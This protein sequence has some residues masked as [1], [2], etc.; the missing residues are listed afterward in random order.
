M[1]DSIKIIQDISLLYE[2]SLSVGSSLDPEE[3]CHNF[4]YTLISRKSLSFG[5]IWLN[6]TEPG[7]EKYCDLFYIYPHFQKA[8]TTVTCSHYILDALAKKP[9]ISI[10]NRDPEFESLVHEKKVG[11]GSYCI[12]S[13]G[14]L[15]FLK[16]FAANR[17]EGFDKLEMAQLKQVVDKLAISLNGCFAHIHLKEETDKKM[18]AQKALAE[19]ENKLRRMIDSSLDAVGSVDTDGKLVEWN[20]QAEKMFGHTREEALGKLLV[21]LI[22]PER[23]REEVTNSVREYL[24]GDKTALV[25][26]RYETTC[27]R[28]D[29]SEFLA[30][31]SITGD[32]NYTNILFVGFIRDITEQRNAAKKM[33]RDRLRMHTLISNLQAGILLV[34]SERRYVLVNQVF[35][36]MYKIPGKP[37][38]LVGTDCSLTG[39]QSK[40]MFVD[41]EHFVNR[42]EETLK[43]R[44]MVENEV[45]K[46]KNGR[47]LERDYI[48]LFSGNEYQG[49]LW[50]YRDVTERENIQQAIRESEEKYRGIL[51]NM[52]LGLLEV[53]LQENII[54]A[55]NTFCQ[56]LGYQPAELIGKNTLDIFLPDSSQKIVRTR[57]KER[58]QGQSSVYE[59]QFKRKNGELIWALVS[60]APIKNAKGEIVGS[61]GIHFDMT[62]R[63]KME[64]ELAQAKLTADR[65][66]LA[67]RQFIT[68]MSHEIRTPINAVIGLTHLLYQTQPDPTQLEYLNGL[69]FSADSLLGIVDNILDISKID[70][71]EIEFE[72]RAFDLGYL[73]GALIQAFKFKASEKGIQI[74][75]SVDPAIK[76]LVIGDP[77]RINQILTNLL[78]NALKFTEKGSVK[79]YTRLL[80]ERKKQ[81]RVEFSV[82][83]SGI[84]IP[85][86]KLDSIFEY[87][88]QG[89]IQINRKF[90]GTGLGLTI[91]KQL[92][93]MQGGTIRVESQLGKG[94]NFIF[95]MS[96]GNSG[97]PAVKG[98]AVQS[99]VALPE[100][101]LSGLRFLIVEDNLLNQK[102]TGKTLETWACTY[103]VANNGLEALEKTAK[104]QFDV[105]LM[106]IHMPEMDGCE[107]TLSIRKDK[108]N[109]NQHTP[110][111]ALTAAAM[112][113][114]KRKAMSVG[115]NGFLTKPIAPK[116]LQEQLLQAIA[117]KNNGFAQEIAPQKLDLRHLS[118]LCNHDQNFVAQITQV[119]KVE[120]PLALQELDS[121]A[122]N[123]S[124]ADAGKIA[125]KLKSN[126]AMFGLSD[127][128]ENAQ[129]IE[130]QANNKVID[131]ARIDNLIRH[132][133]QKST[134]VLQHLGKQ[135]DADN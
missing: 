75:E 132:L 55:N 123:K 62:S 83:D 119:F 4:L 111:I 45:F 56:M 68:H 6:R 89:D 135:G 67:E 15:G 107:T 8:N 118:E 39:E 115:M 128:R 129:L 88:K 26:H 61:I 46:M 10:S 20:L 41:P 86:D 17:P 99:P 90:G 113:E 52:E 109:P 96:F 1:S 38:S 64:H 2:L 51:E 23:Q 77:T 14:D 44:V 36:D 72:Q 131:P 98:L 110:I 11:T 84:G 7:G 100:K 66:R 33:E 121:F 28:K 102:L 85:S 40:H 112:A 43:N 71:G 54:R 9:Y 50:Q 29:G 97:I 69:R 116:M 120:T 125:H 126:F 79:L 133:I 63:K 105:I 81:Y 117:P 21:D 124:W 53:D 24:Q 19:N 58:E 59:L 106:D 104:Q 108:D 70:A 13:M 32:K 122:R 73:I 31:V 47:V 37:E 91:V 22:I 25:N 101:P 103:E 3:N 65:A 92:V 76:N 127:L 87:F 74:Q 35:L 130:E 48:P 95:V 30:E 49:H 42:L 12:F 114:E 134:A 80:S 16:I 5:A 93:E 60:G 34:D 27:I 78:G 94:S 18:E 57:V 82:Q